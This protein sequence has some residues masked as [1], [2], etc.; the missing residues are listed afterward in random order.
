MRSVTTTMQS[1]STTTN[2]Y[3]NRGVAYYEQGNLAKA[4]SDFSEAIH[5]DHNNNAG[6]YYGRGNTDDDKGEF[7]NAISAAGRRIRLDVNNAVAYND[8]GYAYKN[9]GNLSKQGP[10]RF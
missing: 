1:G 5:L 2:A 9:Q 7:D 3:Y 10:Q 6:A 4:I 8:R